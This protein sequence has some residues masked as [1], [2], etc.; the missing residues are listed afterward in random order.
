ME[1]LAAVLLAWFGGVL[2]GLVAGWNIGRLMKRR[3]D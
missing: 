2:L 3:D 1:P